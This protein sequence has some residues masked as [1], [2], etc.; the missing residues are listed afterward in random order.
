MQD[1]HPA[2]TVIQRF[3]EAEEAYLTPRGGDFEALNAG[4]LVVP[5]LVHHLD[6]VPVQCVHGAWARLS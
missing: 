5:R 2:I 3:H 4:I 6:S 1:E